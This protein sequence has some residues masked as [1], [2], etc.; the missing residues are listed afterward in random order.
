MYEK[1]SLFNWPLKQRRINDG[2]DASSAVIFVDGISDASRECRHF[3]PCV[4]VVL[5][6]VVHLMTVVWANASAS[7]QVGD[8]VLLRPSQPLATIVPVVGNR[9]GK[10]EALRYQIEIQSTVMSVRRG[11]RDEKDQV[12]ISWDL[13][14]EQREALM[15][16]SFIR[17]YAIRFVPSSTILDRCLTALDWLESHD[18]LAL[19]QPGALEEILFPVNAPVV[20]PLTAEQRH[21]ICGINE[22]ALSA[23]DTGDIGKQLN[24]LQ[25]SFVRM[26]RARTLDPSYDQTRPPM[27]LTGPG[28]GYSLRSFQNIVRA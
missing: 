25:S 3:S 20:K 8:I 12:V 23:H 13:S 17:Q 9:F 21:V 5:R 7:L 22:G 18:A 24:E 6:E 28:K 11:M 26:V 16:P 4:F 14:P 15:D 1:Y 10:W 2:I 27:I 19:F